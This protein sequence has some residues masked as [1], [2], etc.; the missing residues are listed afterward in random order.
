MGDHN[1]EGIWLRRADPRPQ[2][3]T[4]NPLVALLLRV[5]EV[6]RGVWLTWETF[7]LIGLVALAASHI[8]PG[9]PWRSPHQ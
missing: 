2:L 3:S 4:Q 7:M 6:A 8:T 9:W 1:R 5:A